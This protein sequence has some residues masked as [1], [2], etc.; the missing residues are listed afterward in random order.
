[1]QHT[2]RAGEKLSHANRQASLHQGVWRAAFRQ[3]SQRKPWISKEK[4][5]L[6]LFDS[7]C[8]GNKALN[9][10]KINRTASEQHGALF[11]TCSPNSCL[12]GCWLASCLDQRLGINIFISSPSNVIIENNQKPL[13]TFLPHGGRFCIMPFLHW[14]GSSNLF[15]VYFQ[16]LLML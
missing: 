4:C 8:L 13:P 11:S 6:L 12:W 16:Q 15:S 14:K 1:M 2:W 9:S 7:C 5:Y 3:Y 10:C